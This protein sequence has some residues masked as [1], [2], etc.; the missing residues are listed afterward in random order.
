MQSLETR[1]EATPAVLEKSR[2]KQSIQLALRDLIT[3]KMD[4]S[5]IRDSV[6]LRVDVGYTGLN[7]VCG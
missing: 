6:E 4:G 3:M 2:T 7:H 5:Q 1:L